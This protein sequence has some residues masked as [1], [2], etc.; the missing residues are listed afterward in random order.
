MPCFAVIVEETM[1]TFFSG[2][3]LRTNNLR[4][5]MQHCSV[6]AQTLALDM[7]GHTAEAVVRACFYCRSTDACRQWLDQRERHAA[8]EAPAFC[9]NADRFQK[10]G[11]RP[12]A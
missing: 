2:L 6:D 12:D 4:D 1:G 8:G 5:M 11:A 10:I 7:C 3:E 9:P